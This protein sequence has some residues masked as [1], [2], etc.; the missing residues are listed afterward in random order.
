MTLDE[1][2]ARRRD[3][4]ATLGTARV[5]QLLGP[6]GVEQQYENLIAVEAQAEALA[7]QIYL[8]R[9]AHQGAVMEAAA[10]KRETDWRPERSIFVETAGQAAA[11]ADIRETELH[12]VG[13]RLAELVEIADSTGLWTPSEKV[14]A[15][16]EGAL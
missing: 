4:V 16:L 5:E 3:L 14:R 15:A 7:G 11:R 1:F 2:R 9:L 12:R 10:I 13:R 8:A 6:G